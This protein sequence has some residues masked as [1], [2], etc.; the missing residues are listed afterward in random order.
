MPSTRG[1]AL[2]MSE[3]KTEGHTLQQRYRCESDHLF[4]STSCEREASV[5]LDGL[6]L[7]ERHALQAKLEGQIT[8]WRAILAHIDL[9]SR[10]ATRRDRPEIRE[11]LEVER[12]KVEAATERASRELELARRRMP[13]SSSGYS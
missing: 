3:K 10:E 12:L 5:E 13:I 11:L 4:G 9:W 6:V 7:C 2:F 1:G 8:C